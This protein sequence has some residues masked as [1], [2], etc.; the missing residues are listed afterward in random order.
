MRNKTGTKIQKKT[1]LPGKY[2]AAACMISLVILLGGCTLAVPDAG[3]DGTSDRL[4]G[5]FVTDEY[6][7]LYDMEGYLNDHA[8]SLKDGGSITV[9]SDSR[10]AGKLLA[11]V[12]KSQGEDPSSWKISFG[13]IEG[14]YLL[15]LT[16][17]KD[18][19]TYNSTLCSDGIYDVNMNLKSSDT[20]TETELSGTFC[21][22][23]TQKKDDTYYVNP[24]YQTRSGEIYAV[25]GNG[26]AKQGVTMDDETGKEVPIVP[27]EGKGMA[28]TLSS[29]DTVTKDGKSQTEKCS[30]SIQF[31]VMYQ[32]VRTILYQM[33][34]ANQVLKQ[35]E[36]DPS[37]V[38]DS[39]TLEKDTA[40]VLVETRKEDP[41]GNI[42]K[43]RELVDC[44]ESAF[45]E[46]DGDKTDQILE[47]WYPLKNGMIGKKEIELTK[48]K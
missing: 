5:A 47:I 31:E 32:P 46:E 20:E 26:Y 33:D 18:G 13:G 19:E 7:D 9:E 37:D 45:Q 40:Y 16:E 4:I 12:D 38:P 8:S 36:Y 2:F 15:A 24:V 25:T 23:P 34:E 10:Y 17:E 39:I 1:G 44:E 29:E 30:V 35:A 22:T 6:L 21:Y 43:A 28:A 14:E 48:S 42:L 27:D 41:D 3:T 11:T